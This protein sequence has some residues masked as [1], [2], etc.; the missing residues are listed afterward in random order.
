MDRSVK[1]QDKIGRVA[2][3]KQFWVLLSYGGLSDMYLVGVVDA[4]VVGG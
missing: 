3:R 1:A 4:Q 2:M